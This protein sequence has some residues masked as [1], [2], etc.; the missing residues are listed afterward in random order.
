MAVLAVGGEADTFTLVSGSAFAH[1]STAGRYESNASRTSMLVTSGASEIRL[2]FGSSVS[3]FWAHMYLYQEALPS[4]NADVIVFM[5][6]AGT[7]GE[8]K[9]IMNT[10]GSWTFQKFKTATWT[11]IGSTTAAVAV[12]NNSGASF[13]FQIVRHITA[14]TFN[15]FKD[16]VSIFSFTA[17]D[18]DTDSAVGSVKFSGTTTNTRELNVSQV[19]I[20][21]ESTV[22][23]KLQTLYPDGNGANTSWTGDYTAVDEAVYASGDFIETNTLNNIETY[24]TANIN[25]AYSSYNVKAVVVAAR[26]SNDSG[27]AINDLQAVVRTSATNYTSSNLGLTKDGQEYSVQAVWNTNPNTTAAWT[28]S[29]VNALEVGVKAV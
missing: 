5:N 29:E 20:A 6:A 11:T 10:D 23:W 3:T 17:G 14:G 8:Y 9:V 27:S 18:T 4:S 16:G 28:Q 22:G 12:I 15:V 2:L 13:D 21:D 1:E 26:A 24:T 7:E 25:G 19:I